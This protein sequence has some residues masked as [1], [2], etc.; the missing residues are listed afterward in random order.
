MADLYPA[1]AARCV[2]RHVSFASHFFGRKQPR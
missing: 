2:G 1:P